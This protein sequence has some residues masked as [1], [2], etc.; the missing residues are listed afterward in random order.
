MC[1]LR[2]FEKRRPLRTDSRAQDVTVDVDIDE[3]EQTNTLD[4]AAA[5]AIHILHV[6]FD[7][8]K[9]RRLQP[10]KEKS[11]TW[12]LMQMHGHFSM[13]QAHL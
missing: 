7:A 13:P 1:R 4:L 11:Q 8:W 5:V 2:E 9:R 12:Y 10:I 6:K 3:L